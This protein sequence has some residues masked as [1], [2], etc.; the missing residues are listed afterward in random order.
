[1]KLKMIAAVSLLF[2]APAAA[3]DGPVTVYFKPDVDVISQV[4]NLCATRN[5]M[6]AEQDDHHRNLVLRHFLTNR[7]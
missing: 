3:G 4:S 6:I 5:I 7:L 1:M 2:A